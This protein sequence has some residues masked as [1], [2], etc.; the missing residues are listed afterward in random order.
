M[1]RRTLVAV[2]EHEKDLIGALR[3]VRASGQELVEVYTPYPVHGI[4]HEMGM[5]RSRLPWACLV[6]GLIGLA[7]GL[8]LQ[9]WTSA[10]DWPI[11]V[12]GKP[13]NSLPAFIPVTFEF[14]VL[15]AGIGSF[16]AFLIA[17]RFRPGRRVRVPVDG[18]ADDRFAIVVA[19]S[20][21]DFD[22][23]GLAETLT[24]EHHAVLAEERLVEAA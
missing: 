2:F 16:L 18:L 10:V 6:F 11:N 22:P 4:E 1:S 3:E 20:N 15:F 13:L 17:G 21:A 12:G 5:R 9:I 7:G 19:E 8:L 23:A 14:V 24:V